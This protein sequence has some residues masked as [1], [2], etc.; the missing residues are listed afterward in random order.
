MYKC[1]L[2][3]IFTKRTKSHKKFAKFV[4]SGV[5]AFVRLFEFKHGCIP[6]KS[7]FTESDAMK[8]SPYYFT[9]NMT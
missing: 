2:N 3:I 1:P 7:S 6:M 9:D 5:K 4:A 8:K